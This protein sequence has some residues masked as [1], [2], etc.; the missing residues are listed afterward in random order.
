MRRRRKTP[1]PQRPGAAPPTPGA[2]ET[3]GPVNRTVSI[4]LDAAKGRA[5]IRVGARV[6]ILS[7]LY[8]QELAVV[9]S[10]A[11][12]VIPA[13]SVR[14]DAGR[15]RRVRTIDLEPVREERPAPAAEAPATDSSDQSVERPA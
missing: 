7:G 11:G 5:E 6:R 13:A 9:E 8:E 10:L 12:G 3:R 14:T 15:T 2:P 4:N 1:F